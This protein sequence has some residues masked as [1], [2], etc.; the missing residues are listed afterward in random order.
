MD[1]EP[2]RTQFL[3]THR[4]FCEGAAISHGRLFMDR[5]EQAD[6]QTQLLRTRIAAGRS[7]MCAEFLTRPPTCRALT[8]YTGRQD[9]H[10]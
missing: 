10:G 3:L 5:D 9:L 1:S 4:N 7:S 2:L 6:G 8:L